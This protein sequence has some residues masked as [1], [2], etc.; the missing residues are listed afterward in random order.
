MYTAYQLTERSR[1]KLFLLFPPKYP[2]FIGHHI[3][4]NFGVSA[5][6]ELPKQTT[7]VEIVGYIDNGDGVEGFLVEID[8]TSDR[9]SGGKFHI[10]WSIDRSKG[11]KPVN[12]NDYISS[13][14]TIHPIRIDVVP[15]ILK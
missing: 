6:A 7:L 4:V 15:A 2:E 8:G 1:K 14:T 5:D 10:T 9:P 11:Y 12:T 3:T 13:A